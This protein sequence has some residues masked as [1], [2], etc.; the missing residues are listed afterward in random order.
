MS[1]VQ[2]TSGAARLDRLARSAPGRNRGGKVGMR[3]LFLFLGL[4]ALRKR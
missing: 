1:E 3:I 4:G 2:L